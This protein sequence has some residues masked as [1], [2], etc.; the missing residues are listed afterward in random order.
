ME[1]GVS[2]GQS[3]QVGAILLFAILVIALATYQATAIPSQNAAAEFEHSE[4]V[5]GDLLGVHNAIV[6]AA[7]GGQQAVFV[8]LGLRYTP[9]LFGVNPPPVSGT[10]DVV[11]DDPWNRSIAIANATAT[12]ETGDFWNGSTRRYPTSAVRYRAEYNEHAGAGEHV[13][14][15]TVLYEQFDEQ[16]VLAA[17]Q[18]VVDGRRIAPIAVT[19]SYRQSGVRP[20]S[21][22]VRAVSAD[23][24]TV[25]VTASGGPITVTVPTRLSAAEWRELL[26]S[27]GQLAADPGGYVTNV[28]RGGPGTVRIAFAAGET[29]LIDSALVGVG[30][31][32][33]RPGPAY[34]TSDAAPVVPEGGTTTVEV[35]ARDAYDTGT[36]GSTVQ[37]ATERSDSS[38]SPASQTSD[39]DG[40]V[41]V[42]YTAP[43][44]VSGVEETDRILASLDGDPSGGVDGAA[45]RNVSIPVTV[46]SGSGGSGGSATTETAPQ[47]F[48]DGDGTTEPNENRSLPPATPIGDLEDF[49]GLTA[50]DGSA[51]LT[52]AESGP[53]SS[54]RFDLSVGIAT[55]GIPDGTQRVRV[56][57][58]YDRGTDGEP[59]E[60]TAVRDDGS[61]ISGTA[62]E[63]PVAEGPTTRTVTLE[64]ATQSAVD[65]SGRL[66]LRIDD[67][68]RDG[69]R[70]RDRVTI[71]RLVVLTD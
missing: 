42:T 28:S 71:D 40:R 38:V 62:H 27:D 36:A 33:E 25:P 51:T 14:E 17:G 58:S 68:E 5:Q 7:S 2:R 54:R 37:F 20:G 10:I 55:D 18:H 60:M 46:R 4:A 26:E 24:A 12:G 43:A 31:V 67:T 49:P 13:V 34:L 22:P 29:Y 1:P 8:E 64:A 66:I 65:D 47:S 70:T 3:T 15:N 59:L 32:G 11:T 48:H 9:R 41:R 23:G 44:N 63:L 35:V 61:E 19:G 16:R 53:G 57:Y 6:S 52:E 39:A 56:S 30:T 21:V 50:S 69:D 45:A